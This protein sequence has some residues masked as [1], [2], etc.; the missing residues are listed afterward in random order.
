MR[1]EKPFNSIVGFTR[2]IVSP[3][4]LGPNEARILFDF[5]VACGGLLIAV[6]FTRIFIGQ[7]VNFLLLLMPPALLACNALVGIYSRFRTSRGR[8]KAVIL[9]VSISVEPLAKLFKN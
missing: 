4:S 8:I 5:F 7:P 1:N 6:A 2:K 3:L 9:V